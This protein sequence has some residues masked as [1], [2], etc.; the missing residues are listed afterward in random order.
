MPAIWRILRLAAAVCLGLSTAV[1]AAPKNEESTARSRRRTAV[2]E[3]FESTRDAVVNISST[4]V[5]QVR[6]SG[7]GSLFEDL[8][9]LPRR[10]QFRQNSVGSGFVLHAD[11]YIVTNYHVVARTAERKVIFADQTS[12]DAEVI[13][14]DPRRDLA[15][16]KID[17]DR[18]LQAITLGRSGDVMVGET[19]IA[20]GN[21]L[22]YQHTVT[23]GVVS[24][25]DRL[26]DLGNDAQFTGL[27][28][29]DASINPGSSGGPLLN[30]LGELIGVNTAIR[31]DA[32]NIGFAIPVDQL[33]DVL[34]EM[35]DV[36][37]R[38][39]FVIGLD[40][41]NDDEARVTAVLD[42][43][44]ASKAGVKV[45]DRI[46]GLDG[47]KVRS[48]IDYH[49]A[50]IGRRAGQ[51]IPLT[52]HRQGSSRKLTVR[53]GAAPRPDGASLLRA[54]LGIDAEPMTRESALALKLHKPVG[55]SITHV[56]P[57]TMAHTVGLR[58][59]H[60]ILSIG[61]HQVSTLVDVGNLLEQAESGDRIEVE[62][63]HIRGGSLWRHGV[64]LVAQ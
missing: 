54:R 37:R 26:I 7:F 57:R 9:D 33:R 22:N 14:R 30:V 42:G 5:I 52:L 28:Q 19:V 24:A 36:E 3:V 43:S 12:Y 63:L 16:L 46:V 64:R 10:R 31:A 11:G 41:A 59:G 25:M 8:F 29:T 13:A 49:I 4:Q 55:L 44:P 40:V 20:I 62:V 58:R 47:R 2:V 18:K 45:D 61:R 53:L 51:Q 50:L 17:V 21:P 1:L 27:I 34:P 48:G 15:V 56:E 38:Y 32:Q 23:S 35:L 60:V 39:R 6:T